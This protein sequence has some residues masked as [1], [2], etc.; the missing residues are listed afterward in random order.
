MNGKGRRSIDRVLAAGII[1]ACAFLTIGA[2][3]AAADTAASDAK[4]MPAQKVIKKFVK[5]VGGRKAVMKK[6]QVVIKGKMEIPSQ[7]IS[8]TMEAH[9]KAPNLLSV[10]AEIPGIGTILSGYNG[11]VGWS[12][13]PMMGPSVMDGKMLEQTK[14]EADF[15][16]VLHES[17]R[18]RSMET[19]DKVDFEGAPCWKLK[20]V[21]NNGDEIYEYYNVETGLLAGNEQK[22]NSPM[23]EMNIVSVIEDY[24]EFEGVKSAT[25][26]RQKIG[27]GIEQVLSFDEITYNG[28]QDSD[29]D[30]PAEIKGMLS[31]EG[32]EAAKAEQEGGAPVAEEEK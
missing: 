9:A 21:A 23:G 24:K 7:G 12:I 26:I 32:D 27:P 19:V 30:L 22:Q 18:Y 3:A 28:V 17:D 13:N 8:G 16:A 15:Y 6:D 4:R 10:H 2:T 29:F 14:R 31:S 11:E 1:A 25:K 20:L 5:A